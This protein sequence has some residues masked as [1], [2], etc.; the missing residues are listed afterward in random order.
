MCRWSRLLSGN[1][2]LGQIDTCGK[3]STAAICA[4][5]ELVITSFLVSEEIGVATRLVAT[6]E[7][8]TYTSGFYL[9]FARLRSSCI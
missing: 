5:V 2:V 3:R 1:R 6:L 7:L 4:S 9:G 8:L